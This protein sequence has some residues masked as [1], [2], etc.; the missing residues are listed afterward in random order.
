MRVGSVVVDTKYIYCVVRK[1]VA[2]IL[3]TLVLCLT[4]AQQV[5]AIQW[6]Q[7]WA[8]RV[9]GQH[10]LVE[11]FSSDMRPD[12][13]LRE[14]LRARA[15]YQRYLVGD[16]RILLSGVNPGEHWLA[17]I[18]AWQGGAQGYVSALYFDAARADQLSLS[19]REHSSISW[20]AAAPVFPYW[21]A[22]SQS[23]KNATP[24]AWRGQTLRVFEFDDSSWVRIV[25]LPEKPAFIEK[26]DNQAASRLLESTGSEAITLIPAD[27]QI[28]LALAVS[29]REP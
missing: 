9:N 7:P 14:L 10:L 23:D 1:R 19:E 27:E 15:V 3:A 21:G 29:M 16:G 25:A 17:E 4:P 5:W 28:G 11:P 8:V 22:E 20:Q 6:H 12:A 26:D 13:V 24:H 2:S 18:H